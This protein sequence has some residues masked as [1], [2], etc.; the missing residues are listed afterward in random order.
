MVLQVYEIAVPELVRE[1]GQPFG[2]EVGVHVDFVHIFCGW[3]VAGGC[4]GREI[5]AALAFL[6]AI[7]VSLASI[8]IVALRVL[9]AV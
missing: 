2:Q 8:E 9:L 5:L 1:I 3:R 4:E 7:Y 6:P